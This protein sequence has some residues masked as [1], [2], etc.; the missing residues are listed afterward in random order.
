MDY[1][2]VLGVQRD[3]SNQEIAVAFR[4]LALTYHPQKNLANKAETNYRFCLICK[5][6]E[7]LITRKFSLLLIVCS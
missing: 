3:A 7:I 2:S 1:Y 5:A 4:R 6:Y